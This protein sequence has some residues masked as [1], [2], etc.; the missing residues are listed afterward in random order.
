MPFPATKQGIG[1][2]YIDVKVRGDGAQYLSEDTV[3]VNASARS[4]LD[5]VPFDGF[6]AELH[7]GERVLTAA[8]ARRYKAAAAFLKSSGNGAADDGTTN[9]GGGSGCT[10]TITAPA[11]AAITVSNTAGKVKSKTVG[12]NGLAVFRGLT[13]GKWTITISNGTE[14]ASKT[15]KIK[16]DYSAE[17]TF[18]SSTI[19]IAYPAGLACTATDGVTTL[20]APDTS[21]TWACV[22]PNKGTWAITAGEWSGEVVIT[23]TGQTKN[24]R[25]AK[26]IVK[27]GVVQTDIGLAT[28]LISGRIPTVTQ[29][30]GYTT[31]QITSSQS[32]GILSNNPIDMTNVKTI[33]ADV[34]ITKV[35][36][37]SGV[38]FNGVVLI[39][40]ASKAYS[41]VDNA[42]N[43]IVGQSGS[44]STGR[45]KLSVDVGSTTGLLYVGFA[46]GGIITM[47]LYDLR[48]E[49]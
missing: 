47:N 40:T 33:I 2:V 5:Y 25:L 36:V 24:V 43:A 9:A 15:V 4:G 21:G 11:G 14:T 29:G 18:F 3:T 16:A 23:A 19:N 12:A 31:I 13:E 20:T 49:V 22:V 32:T 39:S 44:T 35:T 26:W 30:T 17:I 1:T 7:K 46:L 27:N 42:K 8:E 6:I 34:D 37:P 28:Q 45:Q 38:K 10:L 48:V 41:S